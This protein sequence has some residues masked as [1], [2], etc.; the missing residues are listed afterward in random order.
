MSTTARFGG[1]CPLCSKYIAKNS[2]KIARLPV[3]LA[4][5]CTDDRRFSLDDGREYNTFGEPIDDRPRDW[6]HEKCLSRYWSPT[7]YVEGYP[8]GRPSKRGET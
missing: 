4:P 3:P 6:C 7:K 5:R 8:G 1:T 2:S